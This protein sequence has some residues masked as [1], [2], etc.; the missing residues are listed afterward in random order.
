MWNGCG[1]LSKVAVMGKEACD[2]TDSFAMQIYIPQHQLFL[3]FLYTV[4]FRIVQH[5]LWPVTTAP[6][7]YFSRAVWHMILANFWQTKFSS[8]Y[9]QAW[10]LTE[11]F[12]TAGQGQCD[13][14]LHTNFSTVKGACDPWHAEQFE[15]VQYTVAIK[16]I[17]HPVWPVTCLMKLWFR[18]FT[19][20]GNFDGDL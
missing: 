16:S 17:R 2:R 10:V 8:G 12:V 15:M 19:I 11:Y 3:F 18:Q 6:R 9:V 5:G 14:W 4:P 1:V 7:F 13:P 20:L